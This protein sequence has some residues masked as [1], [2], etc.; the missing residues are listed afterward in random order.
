MA[1]AS[2][3]ATFL[4]FDL[5]NRLSNRCKPYSQMVHDQ[6][7]DDIQEQH[8]RVRISPSIFPKWTLYR[9][10]WPCLAWFQG[11]ITVKEFIHFNHG[12]YYSHTFF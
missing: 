5:H 6:F 1:L 9:R 3:P 10:S 11:T 12:S 8:S 2:I 7:V 4:P